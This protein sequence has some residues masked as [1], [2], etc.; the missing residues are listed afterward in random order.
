MSCIISDSTVDAHQALKFVYCILDEVSGK[1]ENTSDTPDA[2]LLPLLSQVESTFAYRHY[3]I[4]QGLAVHLLND[5]AGWCFHRLLLIACRPKFAYHLTAV[6]LV[7]KKLFVLLER[8]RLDIFVIQATRLLSILNDALLALAQFDNSETERLQVRLEHFVPI[9]SEI[10][11][12]GNAKIDRIVL[13]CSPILVSDLFGTYNMVA[14]LCHSLSIVVLSLHAYAPHLV[15]N[16][17]RLLYLAVDFCNILSKQRAMEAVLQATMALFGQLFQPAVRVISANYLTASLCLCLRFLNDWLSG[18]LNL[19]LDESSSKDFVNFELVVAQAIAW[20]AEL[21]DEKIET[22]D[23]TLDCLNS[24]VLHSEPL[25]LLCKDLLSAPWITQPSHHALYSAVLG[26]ATRGATQRKASIEKPTCDK[27]NESESP[28]TFWAERIPAIPSCVR[29]TVESVYEM[30]TIE[31]QMEDHPLPESHLPLLLRSKNTLS[32]PTFPNVPSSAYEDLNHFWFTLGRLLGSSQRNIHSLTSLKCDLLQV[33]LIAVSKATQYLPNMDK[34]ESEG[35]RFP[36]GLS[37]F[38][39]LRVLTKAILLHKALTDSESFADHSVSFLLSWISRFIEHCQL[40]P[41]V[42]PSP[43][44]PSSLYGPVLQLACALPPFACAASAPESL[45]TLDNCLRHLTLFGLRHD[46]HVRIW[47]Q[48]MLF[49]MKRGNRDNTFL[50][51]A[52]GLLQG[53]L[54]HA[55]QVP[56]STHAALLV[57]HLSATVICAQLGCRQSCSLY[58]PGTGQSE[59]V[60]EGLDH[61][62]VAEQLEWISLLFEE[63]NVESTSEVSVDLTIHMSCHLRWESVKTD[64]VVAFFS[65]VQEHLPHFS[66]SAIRRICT[67]VATHLSHTHLSNWLSVHPCLMA[68]FSA[69]PRQAPSSSLSH[70]SMDEY[71]IMQYGAL[72]CCLAEHYLGAFSLRPNSAIPAESAENRTSSEGLLTVPSAASSS[73]LTDSLVSA[74]V[75][76]CRLGL[77]YQYV[78]AA[79]GTVY[80]QVQLIVATIH[81]PPVHVLRLCREKLAQA[82]AD[83]MEQSVIHAVECIARLFRLDNI[84]VIKELVSPLFIALVLRGNQ[85]SHL[86][87]RQVVTEVP[88]LR[89]SQDYV[90]KIIQLC[91]LPETLVHIFT[92]TS[93]DEQEV[94]FAFLESHLGMTIERIARLNDVSRLMHLFVLRLYPY[95]VGASLGLRWIASRVLST[96]NAPGSVLNNSPADFL[97]QYVCGILASFD[98]TLLDNDTMFEYRWI[99]LRSLVVFI[100]LLGRSHVTR[101]RAKFMATLKI[102]LRYTTAPFAKVVIKAWRSFIRMLELDAL[103]ELLP[104][105]GATLVS[106][107]PYGPEQVTDLFHYFFLEKRDDIGDKLSCLFFLPRAPKL[108]TCQQILDDLCPLRSLPACNLSDYT[109]IQLK[110]VLSAWLS[111]LTHSSR[112]VRRLA[113]TSELGI[114]GVNDP[115]IFGFSRG[116]SCCLRDLCGLINGLLSGRVRSDQLHDSE[117]SCSQLACLTA[118][119]HSGNNH[120]ACDIFSL[121]ADLISALLEGLTRDTDE[122]MRL[123]YARW[124][125][126]I[127]AIDPSRISFSDRNATSP[128]GNTGIEQ[129][130][131]NDRRFPYYIMYELAKIYLRAASPKQLDSAA[132]AIQEL[133]KLFK[134]PTDQIA[135]FSFTLRAQSASDLDNAD[136][137]TFPYASGEE[138]WELFPEHLRDLFTPLITSRYAVEAFTDWTDVQF[139]L[140]A[141]QPDLNFESWVRLWTGSLSAQITSPHSSLFQYCEPVVKADA[142]FARTLLEHVALQLLLDDSHKGIT[143]LKIE[144]LSILTEVAE[145]ESGDGCI[146]SS[147]ENL[148]ATTS[149]PE[150]HSLKSRPS[151][152]SRWKSWFPLAVQTIFKLLDYLK[153]WLREQQR[154]TRPNTNPESS[155]I[156]D[157]KVI[158]RVS[159][160]LSE[161]PNRLQAKASLRCGGFARALLH[162]ELAFLEDT[163]AQESAFNTGSAMKRQLDGTAHK[164]VLESE[165]LVALEGMLNTYASLRDTDGLAGVLA[166]SQLATAER[167]KLSFGRT[168]HGPQ[169]HSQDTILQ[170]FSI[171]RAMEL[172]NEGQLHMAAAV[173]EHTLAAHESAEFVHAKVVPDI[174]S[175]LTE[176][177]RLMLYGGIFRCE[178]PDPA[179]LHGL[180]ER[181]GALIRHARSNSSDGNQSSAWIRGLNAYR[182][183]AAWRLC[184][185]ETLAESTSLYPQ[186]STWSVGLGKLFFAMHDQNSS[187]WSDAL[188]HLRLSQM[189]ELSAAALEGPGGY[190]RA[191]ETIVRLSLL[192]DVEL[193]AN[194]GEQ[195]QHRLRSSAL[196]T[197]NSLQ[198]SAS[199]GTIDA[200]TS[201]T[202]LSSSLERILNLLDTRIKANQPSFHV[203]EPSLAIHH[204]SLHLLWLKLRSL[205]ASMRPNEVLSS[206]TNR[207]SL[208]IGNN[209]L[210]RAKLARKSGQFMAAY[211]CVLRAEAFGIPHALIERAKLLWRTE[212]RESAQSCLDKGIPAM[213]GQRQSSDLTQLTTQQAMLLRARYSEETSRF[214]F[215]TTKRMYEAACHLHDDCEAAHFRL[216]RYVDRACSLATV[217]KQHDTLLKVALTHYGLAL[218]YGSQFIYQSMPRLL[219]LWLD[220]GTEIARHT[221]SASTNKS[222]NNASKVP[223]DQTTFQE[224]QEIMCRNI[225]RIPAY[226]YYTALG[227]LLSRVCHEHPTVVN[228]LMELIVRIFEAYPLQSIWFLMPLNDSVIRQRRDRC[229]QIFTLVRTKQPHLS[230]FIADCTALCNHLRTICGLFMSTDRREMRSFSLRQSQ[231]PLTRLIESSDFSRILI[232]IHRQLV[233]NLLSVQ[234]RYEDMQRHWPFGSGPDQLV[235]LTRI[236]D[237]V[238]ILGSQTRPKKMTWV[239]SDGRNYI[240]VAKPNDDLR[241]DSRLMELNGMINTFLVKNADTRRRA[242]QIRTYAVIPLSEKGGLIEWVHNTEPFR[243]IITRLYNEIGRPINWGTMSRVAPLLEDPLPVKRDKYLN[244]WLPMFPLVFYRWFLDTFHNPSTWYSARE[245]YAR[246]SAVMSMVG[247]VLGLGDRHTEN[248]LFDSTTGGVVHVDF[249]CV[250]NNGLTLPWPERVPFRLTRNMVHA[251]GPTGYEG[252]FRRCAE[253]VMRLLRHEIDPLLAVFRPIYYDALVEQRGSARGPHTDGTSSVAGSKGRRIAAADPHSALNH[254]L[255]ERLTKAATEKLNGMEDR[256]NGKITEHDGFSQILPMSAEGQVDALINEATDVDQLCQMYKGWMPFL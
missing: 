5:F 40:S 149:I 216:A 57:A 99:A 246:T 85:E 26:Y 230:K 107:M 18:H 89:P 242:L 193:V 178:L 28:F 91:V 231:R 156:V 7:L 88:Y 172:E 20:L 233:P 235:C 199:T 180:V 129:V 177:Q 43:S 185:W 219:S 122:R 194:F 35:L 181:V 10:L 182:A 74:C 106:L 83:H 207:L 60:H 195:I 223:V 133:L 241:K 166:V 155:S 243:T 232:P 68:M 125:G 105:L 119:R 113:L 77:M 31:A 3:Q 118:T 50:H 145:S 144:I 140:L 160:L 12:S 78:H 9:D 162:W 37:V 225:Q 100:Q 134:V 132:L 227:Q 197:T 214:D 2:G 226:Q 130:H 96:R 176:E 121:L 79:Y 139:P 154:A 34:L 76:L 109:E 47:I 152:R 64:Q 49:A 186:H 115:E 164:S 61:H 124:L 187:D 212:K 23:F 29:L 112:S 38:A 117:N 209:W 59:A 39:T 247:Y 94:H 256:L 138:L 254:E 146:Q 210:Q 80:T 33:S 87:I 27:F 127:G 108:L 104:D 90:G 204:T 55:K 95:R 128:V 157:P 36:G 143:Q 171:L 136:K 169:S 224:V 56:L 191:Y 16:A 190:A 6:G 221:D 84:T 239:G 248:I 198:R 13:R 206:L 244:K 52:R 97:G 250:F 81:L 165:G 62:T 167:D 252:I 137:S 147:P 63:R 126:H 163:A 45:Q 123:L 161:I 86:Q 70:S 173:Y 14:V 170:R 19:P 240:I 110:G 217:A 229:Q 188:A 228:S 30:E 103:C 222:A 237:T 66:P 11:V 82:V 150:F 192:S 158:K 58:C 251:L 202:D 114:S 218:S 72:A 69:A 116:T 203:L 183:E 208:A 253:A 54:R 184:D 22:Y 213:Y 151:S 255:T 4:T 32:S 174:F 21:L 44:S 141:T 46:C 238:E 142:S 135:S 201:A 234:C 131:V 53:L 211:T 101:M 205:S 168:L 48:P 17:F 1:L 51:V 75:A 24:N 98:S 179:R 71:R 15:L 159:E 245:C 200:S 67:N 41:S 120:P 65:L 153:C 249:S 215:E 92:R 148:I 25:L 93:K 102:C 73:S 111:A 42:D 189:N 236:E 196:E 8:H 220:Y 175:P